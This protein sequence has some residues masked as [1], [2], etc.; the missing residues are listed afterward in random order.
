MTFHVPL[1][2]VSF[3]LTCALT[4]SGCGAPSHSDPLVQRTL[5]IGR[6]SS[7]SNYRARM[8]SGRGQYRMTINTQV[9]SPSNWASESGSTVRHIGAMTYVRLGN[10]WLA[11]PAQP[12]AYAQQNLPSFARQFYAM[13]RLGGMLVH[14]GGPCRQ[15]G[16][17]G[18]TW[19]IRPSPGSTFGETL[20]ACVAD[21][22]G[23]LLRL[24]IA[25]KGTPMPGRYASETYLITAVGNVAPLRVPAHVTGR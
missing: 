16:L 1:L 9:H 13:T 2:T 19:T 23:A 25:A 6:L 17:A 3:A 14:R 10:H 8:T 18:H 22:S 24:V 12:N 21:R 20:S 11:H 4:L 15:A 5:S 7:L